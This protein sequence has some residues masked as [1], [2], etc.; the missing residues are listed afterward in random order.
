[1]ATPGLSFCID[2]AEHLDDTESAARNQAQ[3]NRLPILAAEIRSAHA[4]IRRGALAIAERALAAGTALAEAK[5]GISHGG[6]TTWLQANTGLTERTARRYMQLAESGIKSATVADLGIRG[7]AESI[8][9]VSRRRDTLDDPACDEWIDEVVALL[10]HGE[11]AS[12]GFRQ[13]FIGWAAAHTPA[14][15]L[16]DKLMK[17][18]TSEAQ[19]RS[20]QRMIDIQSRSAWDDLMEHTRPVAM[21]GAE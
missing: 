7:A 19:R 17:D 8:A 3:N 2:H 10:N 9:R 18:C 5:A 1:M 13:A 12:P 15:K 21:R 20:L 11:T 16:A 4:D 6:W 14:N